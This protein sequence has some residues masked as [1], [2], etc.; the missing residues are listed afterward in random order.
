MKTFVLP[1]K[2]INKNSVAQA[3]GKGANLGE[4]VKANHPIPPGFVILASAF[5]YF[6]EDADINVEIQS[7]LDR[8][9]TKDINSVDR[10][11]HEIRDIINR[12]TI[13][14]SIRREIE[15]NFKKYHL[16]WA[17]VRSSATAE[18]SKIASWAGE[19][20]TYLYVNGK[21]LID[22]V[23]AC[24]SS[25]FTPRAIF[26]RYEKR[27]HKKPISVAVVVQQM[28]AA[29]VAGVVFTAHPVTKDKK[30]MVI[31]AGWGLGE[32]LVSGLIT[33][34]TYIVNKNDRT[35]VD[36][37][38]SPQS[39]MIV[40]KSTGGSKVKSISSAKRNQQK[41]SSKQIL[42]L[43]EQCLKIEK[44]YRHPQDIEWALS[45]GQWSILQTRPITTL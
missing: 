44:H 24:W 29:D 37:N 20:E 5:D 17:A 18:D 43:A 32:A 7:H 3:G 28:V 42:E 25:L 22:T 23:K 16:K 36:I 45:R 19:L 14:V 30:Q 27:L 31:E 21:E 26:Y 8:I 33:P 35:I 2:K 12:S 6:I 11:A 40:K 9:N 39:K 38:V 1:L 34:D 4:M 13:P 10:A 15:S 41:L